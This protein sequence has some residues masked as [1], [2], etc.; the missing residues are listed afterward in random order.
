MRSRSRFETLLFGV[1]MI[2][3]CRALPTTPLGEA[4]TRGDVAAMREMI[5]SGEEPGAFDANGLTALH[6]AARVGQVAAIE[7]LAEAGARIDAFDH[8]DTGWTPMQHAIHKNH[9]AAVASLLRAGASPE[10]T[11]QGGLTPLIMAAGYGQTSIVR[12]LLE[13]G[14]DPRAEAEGVNALW[15]AAGGAALA[16][17][18]DGPAFGTCQPEVIGLLRA[19]A[20]DLRIPRSNSARLLSALSR[21]DECSRLLAELRAP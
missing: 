13:A 16:D 7:A 8:R 19:A 15:S 10:A 5:A 20:P 18:S 2:A 6:W 12:M 3:G 14:A 17:L 11:R 4:A 21:S 9:E 1:L